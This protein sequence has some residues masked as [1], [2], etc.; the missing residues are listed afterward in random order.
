MKTLVA[1][2]ILAMAIASPA[3]AQRA[4]SAPQQGYQ[5]N[6]NYNG[7]PLQEWYRDDSY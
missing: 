6:G 1:T 7:Y 3:L 4:Q 2:A 5:S